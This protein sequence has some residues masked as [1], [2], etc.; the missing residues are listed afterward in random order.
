VIAQLIVSMSTPA[1]AWRL[2]HGLRD[3]QNV[4]ALTKVGTV[5]KLFSTLIRLY[6]SYFWLHILF[7]PAPK[8]TTSDGTFDI[9]ITGIYFS[10]SLYHFSLVSAQMISPSITSNCLIFC[11]SYKIP[12]SLSLFSLS[13][14]SFSAPE[15]TTT[16]GKSIVI[17][18][19]EVRHGRFYIL[20]R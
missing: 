2:N 12:L 10:F 8:I 1:R 17:V 11:I 4:C 19:V 7:L 20:I 5:L 3:A 16:D 14:I 18:V 15:M 6:W 13:C 9:N